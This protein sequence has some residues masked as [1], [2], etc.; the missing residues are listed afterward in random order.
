MKTINEAQTPNTPA[1]TEPEYEWGIKTHS[2]GGTVSTDWGYK[3][4]PRTTG[5]ID[6]DGEVEVEGG[7]Y[8]LVLAV[9]KRLKSPEV[10]EEL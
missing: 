1:V 9:G 4:D 5:V 8:R 3:E 7:Y 2:A 6:E 10:W